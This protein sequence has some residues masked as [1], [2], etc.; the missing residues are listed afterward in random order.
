MF[1]LKTYLTQFSR[2]ED[3]NRRLYS[4][5]YPSQNIQM[6]L[7][8]RSITT[9]TTLPIPLPTP[10]TVKIITPN[11]DTFIPGDDSKNNY[12]GYASQIDV[13]SN[14]K[15]INKH[16]ETDADIRNSYIPNSNSDLY[17]ADYNTD[18]QRVN[19]KTT[20]GD[21]INNSNNIYYNHTRQ[22]LKDEK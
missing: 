15:N 1:N 7:P 13:D 18:I 8:F 5:N 14:L 16:L 17:L 6:P 10:E 3:L 4:R 12:Y 22:Q 2:T 20:G 11:N 9:R 19:Y 21:K